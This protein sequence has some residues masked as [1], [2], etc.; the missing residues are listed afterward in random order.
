MHNLLIMPA[1]AFR[2]TLVFVLGTGLLAMGCSGSGGSDGQ[3]GTD[4]HAS[5]TAHGSPDVDAG[6]AL[7]PEAAWKAEGAAVVQ[8]FKASLM[9]ALM[10]AM[11]DGPQAAIEACRL[12]A[13]GLPEQAGGATWTLGRTSHKV[14][15]TDNAPS[16]WM[17]DFLQAYRAAEPGDLEPQTKRLEDGSHVYVEPIRMQGICLTCHGPNLMPAVTEALAEAYP[18]DEA[19]G[20]A[21]GD[22]RGMFWVRFAPEHEPGTHANASL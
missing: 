22:F 8:P 14:R 16:A 12:K 20:F 9:G 2:W 3:S 17:Q 7:S 10:E 15:N 1:F 18:Q 19:T 13:P 11:P 5:G 6:K 4:P 21:E